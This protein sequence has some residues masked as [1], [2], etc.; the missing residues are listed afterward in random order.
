MALSH[1]L[2]VPSADYSILTTGILHSRFLCKVHILMWVC[3][4]SSTWNGSI[5]YCQW[6]PRQ[7]PIFTPTP[8]IDTLATGASTSVFCPFFTLQLAPTVVTNV[9]VGTF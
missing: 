4:Q 1:Q 6:C 5:S 3:Q 9:E 2:P 8:S 7:V